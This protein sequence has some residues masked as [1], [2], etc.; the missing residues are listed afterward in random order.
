VTLRFP[1]A[2]ERFAVPTQVDAGI[3]LDDL[4]MLEPPVFLAGQAGGVV[5]VEALAGT[6]GRALA[7]RAL[8]WVRRGAG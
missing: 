2:V 6:G 3:F 5:K 1:I 4:G 8:I 7:R